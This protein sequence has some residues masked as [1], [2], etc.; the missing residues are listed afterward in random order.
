M[1]ESHAWWSKILISC[2]HANFS[3]LT[4]KAS[5]LLIDQ[6]N[7]NSVVNLSKQLVWSEVIGSS[8]AMLGNL[9]KPSVIFGNVRKSSDCGDI[10]GNWGNVGIEKLTQLT[11]EKLAGI[12]HPSFLRPHWGVKSMS[13]Y[14]SSMQEKGW[15]CY[16][17]ARLPSR[18]PEFSSNSMPYVDWVCCFFFLHK[19]NISKF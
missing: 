16:E 12:Q 15:Y 5:F 10:F 13:V 17:R 9:W 3:R 11:L 14:N 1:R 8:S 18:W 19:T 2:I 6:L 7:V 4:D